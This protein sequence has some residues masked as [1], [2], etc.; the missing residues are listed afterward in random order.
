MIIAWLDKVG[1]KVNERGQIETNSHLQT[2]VASI[3]AIGDVVQGTMLAH[4]A[5]EGGLLLQSF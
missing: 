2:N 3:Y 5:E 1:V 4:K